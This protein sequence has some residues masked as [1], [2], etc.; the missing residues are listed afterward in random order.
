MKHRK[1]RFI[2]AGMKEE[3]K[4]LLISDQTNLIVEYMSEIDSLKDE[5]KQLEDAIRHI[6]RFIQ[7]LKNG[8]AANGQSGFKITAVLTPAP[9]KGWVKD[10]LKDGKR[11]TNQEITTEYS[12]YTGKPYTT[13]AISVKIDDC[14]KK[15][16]LRADKSVRPSHYGLPSSFDGK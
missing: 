4:D 13:K 1:F 9:F 6:E 14:L 5:I 8:S 11:R 7:S 3:V 2:F 12:K 10:L 16:I 15:G